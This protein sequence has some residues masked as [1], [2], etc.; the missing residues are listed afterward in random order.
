MPL[1]TETIRTLLIGCLFFMTLLAVLYLRQR[2]L[3][4]TASAPGACWRSCCPP[5]A[6]LW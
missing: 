2:R 1:S 5:L 3:S 4:W 6:P